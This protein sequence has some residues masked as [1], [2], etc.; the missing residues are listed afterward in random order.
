MLGIGW[1]E[2]LVIML[3][4]LIVVG[5]AKLPEAARKIGSV[6]FQAQA[7]FTELT[8]SLKA[9]AALKELKDQFQEIDQI[10]ADKTR[11]HNLVNEIARVV[12][13]HP[14]ENASLKAGNNPEASKIVNERH[15]R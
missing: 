6:F 13:I 2:L 15:D 3:V 5:P 1:Q 10:A 11:P 8:A 4:A 9:E 14:P 12:E 7:A